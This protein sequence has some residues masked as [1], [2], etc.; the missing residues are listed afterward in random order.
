MNVWLHVVLYSLLLSVGVPAI[1]QTQQADSKYFEKYGGV[2]VSLHSADFTSDIL[3]IEGVTFDHGHAHDSVFLYMNE[4]GYRQFA[5]MGVAHHTT[6][7]TEQNYTTKSFEEIQSYKSGSDCMPAMDFYPTYEGYEDMMYAFE[8]SYP[9]FCRIINIGT[10]AS[11][12]KILVAQLGDNPDATEDEPNFFYTS[13]MHGDETGGYPS[14]LMLIDHLLCNYGTDDRLTNMMDNINIYINPLANP[15]GTYRGGNDN[16]DGA[17]R[18][19]N[20]FSDLNRNFPDPDDG[21]HPDNK[22]YQEETE[23]FMAF[24]DAY[25]IHLACNI[26]GGAEVA[27]YP[28]DTWQH[29]PADLDWWVEQCRAYADTVQHYSLDPQYFRRFDNGITNGYDWYEVRGGRQDYM[30]YFKRAREFTLEISDRKL[31]RPDDLPEVWHS[32][33]AAL[34]NYMESALFG[35]RGTITDCITGLPVEAEVI[36]PGYDEDNSSVFSHPMTGHYYRYLD[37]GTYNLIAVAENYDT[38]TFTAEI[39]DKQSTRIDLEIC[40]A[41]LTSVSEESLQSINIVYR[42][43]ALIFSG[44]PQGQNWVLE[45]FSSDGQQ[46]LQ[47]TVTSD[48]SLAFLPPNS[49]IYV[50]T[51]STSTQMRAVRLFIQ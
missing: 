31:V 17:I 33:A 29:M 18:Y 51:L 25:N 11:G 42:D 28:W 10:L 30:N 49:G 13:T 46:L 7:R 4:S 43:G 21:P 37:N 36:I 27:N 47:S 3:D 39:S 34:I 12:R 41:D 32:N 38:L 35:L 40:P 16:V 44:L 14:M 6:I 22:N 45:V 48:A 5:Q 50:A 24:A 26:H 9:E 2:E 19:N 15:N 23:I 20:T 1:A 8:A